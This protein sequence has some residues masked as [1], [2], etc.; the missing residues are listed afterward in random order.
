MFTNVGIN[1]VTAITGLPNGALLEVP[2]LKA[3]VAAAVTEAATVAARAGIKTEVDP[4]ALA[5]QVIR[6]TAG[7]RSSMLQDITRGKRTEIDALNGKVCEL[8]RMYG[9]PAP[10]NETLTALIKGIEKRGGQ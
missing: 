3:L 5:F 4:V 10:V 6:D 2:E 7:N 9:V 8:G 1:A